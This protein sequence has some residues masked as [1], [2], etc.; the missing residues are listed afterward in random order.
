MYVLYGRDPALGP[1]TLEE[2]FEL[3]HPEDRQLIRDL[4]ILLESSD[5]SWTIEYRTNPEHG[6]LRH[7]C[8]TG[9][10]I[11][12]TTGKP[13]FLSGGLLDITD[14]KRAEEALRESQAMLETAQERAHLGNWELDPHAGVGTW[15][16][17]M[18]RLYRCDPALGPPTFSEFLD[19]LHPE[20][21]QTILDAQ[22][23][24]LEG[25]ETLL[26]LDY[27]SNPALGSL[28]Y[29]N[30]ILHCERDKE[31]K[32]LLL[33]GTV[34][35]VT[36][37]KRAE[38]ALR[39]SEE[40]WRTVVETVPDT[41]TMLDRQGTILF[42]NRVPRSL[43]L[44]RVIGTCAFDYLPEDYHAPLRAAID[45]LFRDG[46]PYE[47]EIPTNLQGEDGR[48]FVTRGQPLRRGEEVVAALNVAI[49]ITKRKQQEE[50]IRASL[51]EKEALLK[52]IHHRVKNNLQIISSL[53]ALQADRIA[54]PA[55]L[56]A[57]RES[58]DRVRAMA[59][60]HQD[61]YRSG[62]LGHI[63]LSQH[64]QSLCSNLFRSYGV[65]AD[66]IQLEPRIGEVRLDLER[67]VPC[68]LLLNELVSNAL[69]HA[70]TDGR[71]GRIRVSMDA[72]PN[73]EYTLLV[74]DDGVGLPPNLDVT[75]A[76][77]LGLQ[78]IDMLTRQ[79][80]GRLSVDRDG[81]TAFRITFPVQDS[82][83]L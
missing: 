2:L 48:F 54:D 73:G 39:E 78:L 16:L 14:R 28:R 51:R 43:E 81:G 83:R 57:F 75:R 41:I 17:E 64:V 36:E 25:H 65:D 9:L 53:L 32:P 40:K 63:D 30:G 80:G 55:L 70:F 35:D 33:A 66:R 69:K 29:F 23:R 82:S 6:P 79:L 37:R 49:D 20:D 26:T 71:R 7:L 58:R 68:G 77:S 67:A 27:R 76:S 1:P 8:A 19:L 56:A 24:I 38:I 15:S 12:D 31:G 47:M 60:I 18:Y 3:I 44:S 4:G 52:E 72:G 61:L 11:C 50:S 13:L 45:R 59:I 42:V 74:G 46:T 34:Q 21:R 10:R 62:D 5:D 22:E